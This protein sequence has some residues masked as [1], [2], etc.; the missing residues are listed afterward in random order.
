MTARIYVTCWRH[1]A[2]DDFGRTLPCPMTPPL[3]ETYVDITHESV[4]SA[5]FP[6][7]TSFI[8]VRAEADC[9]IAFGGPEDPIADPDYHVITAGERLFYGSQAGHKIAVIEVIR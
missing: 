5:A 4:A 6:Q 7:Y 1:Q 3:A 2:T 9:A 8:T